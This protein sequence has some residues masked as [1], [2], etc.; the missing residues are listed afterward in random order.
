MGRP[1]EIDWLAAAAGRRPRPRGGAGVLEHRRARRATAA[2]RAAT[3]RWRWTWRPRTRCSPSWRRLGAPLTAVSEERGEVSSAAA[4]DPRGDRPGRRLAERQAR[5]AVRVRVDRGGV[6]RSDGR[7]GPGPRDGA[8]LRASS[9]GRARRG[10]L[11][12]RRAAPAARPGG[13]LEVLGLE[14]ARPSWWPPR[15][16]RS[17][18]LEARRL[19]VLGSVAPSLCLVAA[20]RLDAMMSLREV[21]SVDV[22]AGAADRARGGRRGGAPGRRRP[23]PGD[24]LPGAGG[25]QRR[26]ARPPCSG[27]AGP[28]L[29]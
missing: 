8:R 16:R 9:G 18:R 24:A 2:A 15:P 17:C 1:S 14:T 26:A 29:T 11:P 27:A 19:R 10:R 6:G 21:R 12:R 20:G 5:P 13:A 22:A 4:A 28:A 25:A 23:R 7:R 3:P